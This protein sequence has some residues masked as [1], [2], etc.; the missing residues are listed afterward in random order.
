MIVKQALE[1]ITRIDTL[2]RNPAV[3]IA[4]VGYVCAAGMCTG[5]FTTVTLKAFNV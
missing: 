1:T 4:I 3:H 5:K 2:A